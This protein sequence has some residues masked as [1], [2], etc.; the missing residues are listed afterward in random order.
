MANMVANSLTVD[1]P[2]RDN[3]RHQ[4]LI[5]G[6]ERTSKHVSSQAEYERFMRELS[7]MERTARA[8]LAEFVA[9]T[10]TDGFGWLV[11]IPDEPTLEEQAHWREVLMAERPERGSTGYAEFLT[12][13][14]ANLHHEWR[15]RLWGCSNMMLDPQEVTLTADGLV[16]Q[17]ETKWTPPSRWLQALAERHPQ[18]RI[19]LHSSDA[20]VGEWHVTFTWD[21]ETWT[22]DFKERC[23]RCEK[24]HGEGECQP[25]PGPNVV[26]NED[27]ELE[28]PET[29]ER[30]IM[31]EADSDR[32]PWEKARDYGG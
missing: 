29:R 15:C 2:L 4:E 8:V 12:G 16:Y 1:I 19:T 5:Q 21:G 25:K 31:G 6:I 9:G 32:P 26:H 17:F 27:I 18:W 10:F 7:A 28:P 3:Q 13:H 20:E 14:I 23:V 22:E 30:S 24:F 11:P